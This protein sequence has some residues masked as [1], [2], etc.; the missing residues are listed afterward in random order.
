MFWIGSDFESLFSSF[1][2]SVFAAFLTFDLCYTSIQIFNFLSE[3]KDVQS[4]RQDDIIIDMLNEANNIFIH[5]Q[6][7]YYGLVKEGIQHTSLDD[8][9]TDGAEKLPFLEFERQQTM[10]AKKFGQRNLLDSD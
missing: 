10:K 1:N 6:F 7:L 8:A 9:Y 3:E 5:L 2:L 4:I